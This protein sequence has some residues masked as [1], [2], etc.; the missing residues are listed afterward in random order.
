MSGVEP[1]LVWFLYPI[2]FEPCVSTPRTLKV[3]VPAPPY[4]VQVKNA[5]TI[6]GMD[7]GDADVERVSAVAVAGLDGE[8]VGARV[9]LRVREASTRAS[10]ARARTRWRQMGISDGR[11]RR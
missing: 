5:A 3:S 7:A 1:W 9:A 10:A 6:F 4:E 11:G 8:R 2:S